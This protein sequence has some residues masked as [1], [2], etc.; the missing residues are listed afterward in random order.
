M[1]QSW[2][3]AVR[4]VGTAT[5]AALTAVQQYYPDVHW[6]SIVLLTLVILGIHVVPTAPP[7]YKMTV[8]PQLEPGTY[9]S[10]R[11]TVVGGGGAGGGG[12]SGATGQGGGGGG[13]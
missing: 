9:G 4:Y 13:R 10:G 8:Q 7:M 3:T 2:W 12:V 1:T 11:V 5:A 6:I